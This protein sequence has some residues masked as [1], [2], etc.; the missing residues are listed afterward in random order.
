MS[1]WELIRKIEAVAIC[2]LHVLWEGCVKMKV[3]HCK[4]QGATM[5]DFRK[6]LA[7]L[8]LEIRANNPS[9]GLRKR[10][11]ATLALA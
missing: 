6:H 4:N 8:Q 5:F 3:G 9:H 1:K 11:G 2:G 10:P 7:K